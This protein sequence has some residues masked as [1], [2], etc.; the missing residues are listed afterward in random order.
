M[1]PKIYNN[2]YL[3]YVCVPIYVT[4]NMKCSQSFTYVMDKSHNN[5]IF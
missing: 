1:I 4:N 3:I 5:V 2:T